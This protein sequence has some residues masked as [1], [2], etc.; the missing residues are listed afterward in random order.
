MD[1][2]IIYKILPE[3]TAYVERQLPAAGKRNVSV[4]DTVEAFDLL[5]TAKVS[6][7]A[8]AINICE[9][10]NV[11]SAELPE[12]IS[13]TE[14]DQV[15]RGQ[16]LAERSAFFGLRTESVKAPFSSEIDS[17]DWDNGI[18]S[19]LLPK[20]IEKLG[21]GVSGEIVDIADEKAFLIKTRAAMVKGVTGVGESCAGTLRIAAQREESLHAN[22]ILPSDGEKILVGGS[23]LEAE[24][25][26]KAQI[27]GVSG[28]V[29]SSIDFRNLSLVKE[30]NIALMLTEGFGKTQMPKYVFDY[31]ESSN[32]IYTLLMP[33]RGNLLVAKKV[34][35]IDLS[36]APTKFFKELEVGDK[37][38]IFSDALFGKVGKVV[39][40]NFEFAKI[41]T[42]D[43]TVRVDLRNLGILT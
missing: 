1:V 6:G 42:G 8:E 11:E 31:L 33:E 13:V 9:Q 10:L 21:A 24:A 34:E 26:K 5:G 39:E 14:G 17:I 2:P 43:E 3:R 27:V 41:E 18:I 37:V 38:Q 7:G 25:I 32:K 29:V 15:E 19:L 36:G 28:I 16:V 22:C 40:I 23:Y 20:R 12:I 4:G 35:N 30:A